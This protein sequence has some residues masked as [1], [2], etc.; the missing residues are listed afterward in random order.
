MM[1]QMGSKPE[2]LQ[3][4]VFGGGNVLACM[5]ANIGE[6][7]QA[8]AH[9]ELDRHGIPVV[10]GSVGGSSSRKVEF[11]SDTGKVRVLA[12]GVQRNRAGRES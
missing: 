1:R 10:A 6:R 11:L 4:K 9:A 5:S 2:A 3:A 7:N 12:F 8:A